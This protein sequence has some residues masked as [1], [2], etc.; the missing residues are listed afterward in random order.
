VFPQLKIKLK[1]HHF[2]AIEVI[3]VELQLVLNTLT[4]QDSWMHLKL[5]EMLG[6]LHTRKKGLLQR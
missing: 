3:E 4:E 5:A 1:G 6:I 2:D